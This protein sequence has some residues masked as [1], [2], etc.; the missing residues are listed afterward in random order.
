MASPFHAEE[1]KGADLAG[2]WYPGSKAKL[3]AALDGYLK[4]APPENLDGDILAIISPH[5]GYQF[6]GPVAAYGFNAIKD[7][8]F[9][10][11]IVVGFSH[12]RHFDGVSV[13]DRGAFR[14]PLGDI[15]IDA[16]LAKEIISKNK[17]LRFEPAI[18]EEEN[19]VEMQ[20]PFIQASLGDVKIVPIAF[21]TQNYEDAEILSQALADVLRDRRD[22]VVVASTDLSHYHPYDEA[23]SMDRHTIDAMSS[24]K[25]KEF[26]KDGS[27]GV[28]EL[29]GLMPVTTALL[30]A[31]KLGFNKIKLLKYANSGD[32]FGDRSKVVGYL[33]AAIYRKQMLNDAQ[34]KRLLE[35][36]RESLTSY[37]R[38]GKR[39]KFTEVDTT[40]SRPMGAFVTLHENGELR[41][42]IG[43]IVGHGPLYQT[44]ADMAIE[45]AT[46][47][48]RFPKLS[49]AEIDKID[50]EISVL[51]EMDKVASHEEV[52]IPG[53]GVMIKRGSNSGVFLPQVADETG[54]SKEEFL[55]CLCTH[56]AGLPSDAWKDPKTDIYVFT[57]E[58]FGE[59]E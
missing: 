37:V 38:D 25:A 30:T 48:P 41:G 5:A 59:K 46:G 29:C 22:V 34:R 1:V 55:S 14:T 33:S 2:S 44:V 50:I 51:S 26:Y 20:I 23:N 15:E 10:T 54:W 31:E 49:P 40:L 42:C 4:V 32:T 12:R 8:N 16:P 19:S 43:N 21:G 57:A 24:L 45:S 9:K 3:K 58:V 35:I 56:K 52:K 6:S 28:C 11:V 27:V 53:H 36:A 17:R 18:F 39:K 13:Y 7:K 47:D